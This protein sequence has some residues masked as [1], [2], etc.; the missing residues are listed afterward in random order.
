MQHSAKKEIQ[1]YLMLMIL[2]VCSSVSTNQR[3]CIHDGLITCDIG[4]WPICSITMIV[5]SVMH[6][7]IW[8]W[9]TS[10]YRP[11]LPPVRSPPL[12]SRLFSGN[13]HKPFQSPKNPCGVTLHIEDRGGGGCSCS[14]SPSMCWDFML[15]EGRGS[16]GG[17]MWPAKSTLGSYTRN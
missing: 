15:R 4:F 10:D 9:D 12:S 5:K 13:V 1:Q 3:Q 16:W 7:D 2:C 17:E 6:A 8:N 14:I 11:L